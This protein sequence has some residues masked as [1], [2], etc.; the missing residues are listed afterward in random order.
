MKIVAISGSLRKQSTNKTALEALAFITPV[1][2]YDGLGTLPHFN[3]DLD[4]EGAAPPREVAVL[5]ERLRAADAIV[6]STPEYAH[7]LPGV[8]KNM[9]D[10]LVSDGL[11]V[12]KRVLIINAT[13]P[14][15]FA[16]LSLLEI[17][18]T[19]NWNV[20]KTIELPI[21]GKKL[22]AEQ[23]ANQF[24]DLLRSGLDALGERA[25]RPQSS[26]VSRDAVRIAEPDDAASIARLI[27][28]LGYRTSEAETRKRLQSWRSRT[29]TAMFVALGRN[30]VIGMIH[31]SVLET[32]EHELR[33]EIRALVVDENHRS[34]GVGEKLVAAAESWAR[35]HNLPAM[36]VRSNVKRE[37]A[38]TFYE[39]VGYVVTKTQNIFDKKL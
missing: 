37:R 33:A 39:R 36:R 6:V 24:G 14:A 11:L 34:G 21:R 20:V 16:Q 38:R 17:L 4:V 12:D 23:V 5:R 26:R 30:A 7:G 31:V 10:W 29:D 9:L 2:L 22:T 13:P 35:E 19:M 1:D 3:P 32:I 18:K 27:D 25:S 8:L 15:E 28:Q